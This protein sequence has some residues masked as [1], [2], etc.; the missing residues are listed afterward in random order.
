MRRELPTGRIAVSALVEK[1]V[2]AVCSR[3][4][5]EQLL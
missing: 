5:D 2:R 4:V 3:R 1:A